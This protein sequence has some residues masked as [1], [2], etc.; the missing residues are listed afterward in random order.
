MLIVCIAIW[1]NEWKSIDE[2]SRISRDDLFFSHCR[3]FLSEIPSKVSEAS[4]VPYTPPSSFNAGGDVLLR[5][6][7]EDLGSGTDVWLHFPFS[8]SSFSFFFYWFIYLLFF[9]IFM[10]FGN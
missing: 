7:D 3:R 5:M 1:M 8:I 4:I 10:I 2:F 6:G 9:Y